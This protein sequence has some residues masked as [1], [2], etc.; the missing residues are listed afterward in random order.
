MSAYGIWL[1][2]VKTK[3]KMT[4]KKA[5][6][7]MIFIVMVTSSLFA[8]EKYTISGYVR[9]AET[10]EELIGVNV[11][12]KEK[13]IGTITN[14]YG[15]YS[16]TLT[17]GEWTITFSY[18]G[19]EEEN[20]N[21][22]LDED[23]KINIE[24]DVAA[25]QME[26]VVISAT[27]KDKN[28]QAVEMSTTKLEIKE[29][30]SIPVLF[31]EQDILKTVQL[32]PGVKSAGEGNSGFYVRGGGAD[33]NLILLDEALVYNA[34]H[35]LG[36][37]LVFN[38]DA[39][40]DVKL[41][42]GGM[43]A[44]Y[45]GRLS[46]VLDIKMNEGNMKEY[47][48]SG[49]LGLISSRLAVEGPIV[50]D[51]GSFLVTGRRTYADMFLRAFGN[52]AQ[53]K[54]KLY[55][56]D[57]NAKA[58]YRI[59]ENNR[60][61]LSGYFGRDVFDFNNTFGFDWGN[62]TSTL[63]WNHLYSNKLFSNT[64]LIFSDYD[65]IVGINPGSNE[66]DIS[67]GIQDFTFKQ[68]YQYF[69]TPSISLKFGINSKYH[70]FKPGELLTN[71][72]SF[73]ND[74]ILDKKNAIENN[75]YISNE[76][77]LTSWFKMNYGL[78]V[79]NFT[80][81]GPQDV[82]SYDLDGNITD[83]TSYNKGDIIESYWG[84]EP[85]INT[86]FIINP[87]SSVKA[88]YTRNHQY[89]HLLSNSTSGNP[90]DLWIPSSNI[91]KPQVADQFALGYFRNFADNKFESSIEVYYKDLKNQIDYKNGADILLNEKVES[92]LV[93][94]QGRS[95]GLELFL[96]KKYGRFNGWIGYTFSR[97]ERI[98]DEI[99]DGDWY[100]AKHDRTHDISIVGIYELNKKWTLG[101]TWVYYT[102]NAVTF[103]IGKYEIDGRTVSLY[104]DRNS[105]RMPDY[106]R[107]DLSL[108]YFA[109]KTDNYESSWNFSVY[110][111]YARHNAYSINFEEDENNPGN[112]KAVKMYLFSIVPSIT[113]NFKF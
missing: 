3:K 44:E 70:V 37:F 73:V 1:K 14:V 101:A 100:P 81:L 2:H 16:L 66:V 19:Y 56:Y 30:K 21:I 58:N 57:L 79:S 103:P 7:V 75:I 69:A 20:I 31:G 51:K 8:Q 86:N 64:S 4:D 96:K 105:S 25:Q 32:I 110:N 109:K 91:V 76:H 15:Y 54:T 33:Q 106:H 12:S 62:T 102:G 55:F 35:L 48:V 41:I 49:G 5:V 67:S 42:K 53:Q 22:N 84:F 28:I 23:K 39:I 6:I 46:S 83:T 72:E 60:L 71:D 97:T 68:D 52:S 27:A 82:Y 88:S 104:E 38:S 13:S 29:I 94:G 78:R 63:R 50:E 74:K 92:Q 99:N 11:I 59:N 40:K 77:E 89:V 61:F 18:L 36:F 113:W 45:G 47:N 10:G 112:T 24:L 65:Y 34:S 90:T 93:F 87:R 80:M 43:P 98:F 9:D 111:A 107:L 95:Y 108:T 85:R 26:E 17:E